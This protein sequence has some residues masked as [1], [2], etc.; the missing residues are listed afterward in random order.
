MMRARLLALAAV[1]LLSACG[2]R[3]LVTNR[4]TIDFPDDKNVVRLNTVTAISDD[5]PPSRAMEQRVAAMREALTAQ[6]DEWSVRY[7]G[8]HPQYERLMIDRKY[9]VVQ[10]VERLTTIPRDELSR[11]FDETGISVAW[12]GGGGMSELI[13][14]PHGST[15][16]TREQRE[17]VLSL[18]HNFSVDA[19]AYVTA[20]SHLYAWLDANPQQANF[21][22]TMILSDSGERA[23]NEE[24]QALIEAVRATSQHITDRLD[25]ERDDQYTID[26]QFD[27]V[28]N[29]FS[30]EMV[31][32]VP[33]R[34]TLNENFA[35]EKDNTLTIH[36]AGLLDAVESLEGKWVAPDPL[37]MSLRGEVT[38]PQMMAVSRHYSTVV[39]ASEIER[40]VLEKL[41]PAS[42]YRVRWNE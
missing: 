17:H 25:A 35:E 34:I 3:P 16:A 38:V 28:F 14:T 36:R 5:H 41:K 1:A 37:G 19:A 39:T 8:L 30:S 27:L 15:R 9:G 24:E 40:A 23:I 32:H 42:V 20:L 29:P 10:R 13:I 11:F 26:E 7:A 22:Y 6:R 2:V 21:A 4:V 18:L 31:V 12:T 33:R